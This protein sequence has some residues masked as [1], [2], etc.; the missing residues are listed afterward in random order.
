MAYSIGLGYDETVDAI[1]SLPPA[2]E[3]YQEIYQLTLKRIRRKPRVTV[4]LQYPPS[5]GEQDTTLELFAGENL[6]MGMLVR[7]V[8]LNDPLAQRFDT[9]NGGNCGA[10]GLCRTC[11]VVVQKGA[12][13]LN[14]QRMN[15]QQMFE[16]APRWRLACKA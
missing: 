14:P 4:K 7:G 9:K 11:S 2:D 1:L 3:R 6:R 5:Q 12:D 8:K 15:E 13:L 10:G 16:D